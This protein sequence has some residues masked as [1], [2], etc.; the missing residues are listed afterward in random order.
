LG[1]ATA[2][3][4][5]A[6]FLQ[7]EQNHV[8]R[9]PYIGAVI[10]LAELQSCQ[11]GQN[12]TSTNQNIGSCD[13]SE[14]LLLV[15]IHTHTA[16][17]LAIWL[18]L[19]CHMD[20]R[21]QNQ[22]PS[23]GFITISCLQGVVGSSTFDALSLFSCCSHNESLRGHWVCEP[24]IQVLGTQELPAEFLS[25]YFMGAFHIIFHILN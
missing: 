20:K 10:I 7:V 5:T 19:K 21:S 11:I 1:H 2:K 18:R 3:P 15:E 12:L 6:M 8:E 14:K 24:V 22:L 13:S 23:Y 16:P 4:T 9:K 25:K 17:N